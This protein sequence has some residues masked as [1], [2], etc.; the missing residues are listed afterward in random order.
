M[1]QNSIKHRTATRRV[2]VIHSFNINIRV[3]IIEQ[4]SEEHI[5]FASFIFMN[6]ESEKNAIFCYL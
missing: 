1:L 4:R 6:Y 5:Q 3:P 2:S